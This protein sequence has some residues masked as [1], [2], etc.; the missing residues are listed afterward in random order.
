L[1]NHFCLYHLQKKISHGKGTFK[2]NVIANYKSKYGI[3]GEDFFTVSKEVSEIIRDKLVVTV[4]GAGDFAALNLPISN[5][6]T[7]DLQ[8]YFQKPSSQLD[9]TGQAI[10]QPIGL[11]SLYQH[12]ITN[13][14][15]KAIQEKFHSPSEDSIAHMEMFHKYIEMKKTNLESRYDIYEFGETIQTI[16]SSY[17][18]MRKLFY[19]QY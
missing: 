17:D 8:W 4:A 3:E 10:N 6:D 18:A 1:N 9:K 13:D 7:F 5:Y 19:A 16:K 11:K 2:D 14:T 15:G 12:F